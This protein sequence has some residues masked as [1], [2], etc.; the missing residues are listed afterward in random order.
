MRGID[1][2]SISTSYDLL[3]QILV[4]PVDPVQDS[5]IPYI[6][7]PNHITAKKGKTHVSLVQHHVFVP[8][9]H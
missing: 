9:P 4:C 6:S 2:I 8:V 3:Q 7:K 1:P 5:L